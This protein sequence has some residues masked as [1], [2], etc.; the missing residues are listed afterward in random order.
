M[1]LAVGSD[2]VLA[3]R[4]DSSY[5]DRQDIASCMLDVVVDL[6]QENFGDDEHANTQLGWAIAHLASIA[7]HLLDSMD[8]SEVTT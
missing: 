1:Q 5:A 3:I 2:K 4:S 8:L 7:K 6:A